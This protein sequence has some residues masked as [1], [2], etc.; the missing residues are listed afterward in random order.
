MR[1]TVEENLEFAR[2]IAKKL[3]MSTAPVRVVLPEKG[4]S[5]LDREGM[6]FYDPQATGT[7]LNEL[8][9]SINKTADHQV[10]KH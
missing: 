9:K 8:E 2:F 10:S 6:P 7:L 1:T 4:I 3:N 5:L